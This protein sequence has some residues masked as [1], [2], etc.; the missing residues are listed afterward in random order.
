MKLDYLSI[1]NF[2]Q[3]KDRQTITFSRDSQKKVTLLI[4]ESTYGKTTL[5]QA[6][7]WVFFGSAPKYKD[8]LNHITESELKPGQSAKIIG[9]V[10]LNYNQQ[11]YIIHREQI[12]RKS[13]VRVTPDESFLKIN[14][15]DNLGKFNELRGSDANKLIKEIM[16]KDLFPYFFL[17]GENLTKI[18][19]EMSD[20]KPSNNNEFVK[21]V[22]GLLG[23]NHRYA[24]M[25]HLKSLS[26]LYRNEIEKTDVDTQLLKIERQIINDTNEKE[27][28]EERLK[29]INTEL[30]YNKNKRDELRND[31][32]R[33]SDVEDKQ[34]RSTRL[35]GEIQMLRDKIANEE[36]SIF[37]DFSSKSFQYFMLPLLDNAKEVLKSAKDMDKGIPGMNVE[38]VKYMLDNHKCICG[39]ELIEGSPEWNALQDWIKYLPPNNIGYEIKLYRNSAEYISAN[40]LSYLRDFEGA[41]KTLNNDIANYNSKIQEKDELDEE[42]KGV[43]TV[44]AKKEEEKSY[45]DKVLSLT[46]EKGR[47]DNRVITLTNNI[48]SEKK[49]E[50]NYSSVNTKVERLKNYLLYSDQ[51][52][53][54]IERDCKKREQTKKR[55]LQDAI[56]EIF[57]DFYKSDVSL[58]LDESYAITIHASNSDLM[59]N[60][61]SGGQGIAVALAFIGAIIK[62]NAMKETPNS[63]SNDE[64]GVDDDVYNDVYPLVLDAP[65]SNFD[66]PQMNSFSEIMPNVTDQIIIFINRKDG[67]I[68]KDKTSLSSLIGKEYTITRNS[69]YECNIEEVK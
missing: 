27:R 11:D 35:A 69:T 13:Q 52:Y 15:K 16:P 62:V 43:P 51:M 60:F 7:A 24:A 42:I 32:A 3:F 39:D 30:D 68:L 8:P 21:A 46:E 61:A 20:G 2:R 55:Q 49:Q 37:R 5:I 33:Y 45:D 44:S 38:S 64:E 28:A 59:E 65:T 23:F 1:Q 48:D 14:Y 50:A 66:L 29:Q 4:A 12:F 67:G 22:K 18:G 47:L 17:E 57:K 36:K 9:E 10:A 31:I 19:N 53:S 34:K 40:G 63:G 6:F 26:T 56:N 58:S 54:V 25:K 41:R